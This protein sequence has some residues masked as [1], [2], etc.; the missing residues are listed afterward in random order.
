M[1][2]RKILGAL[3][4][5]A[6]CFTLAEVPAHADTYVPGTVNQTFNGS[7][8]GWSGVTTSSGLCIPAL[9]CPAASA[10]WQPGGSDGNGYIS[11]KFGSL[12]S[13]QTGTA[14]S[15][16]E[17]PVFTYA[18]LGGKEPGS[19][20]FDMDILRNVAALLDLSLLNNT[21]YQVDL[22]D[23]TNGKAVSVVPSTPIAPNGGWTSIPSA[24]VNPSLLKIGRPYKIRI[25]TDYHAAVT[26]VA[27]GEVGYDNVT[28][29]TAASNGG[30]GGGNNG[31]SGIT[32]IKQLRKLTK[33][34][35]LPS[36]AKVDGRLLVVKL[37]CPAI[38]SPKPCQ[39]QFAGLQAGR[40]SKSA[41]A[42]KIVTIKAGKERTVKIR[43]KPKYVAKYKSAKKIWTKS[44][45]RVGKVRVTVRKT[46]KV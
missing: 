18:G 17:S 19:V 15:I 32:N 46:M 31:G 44:I 39:I 36:S 6:L 4:A 29:T 22:V 3:A 38:A 9:L 40:F 27:T 20:T 2:L 34:Y 45:V 1:H 14:G 37:R 13:T 23:Q 33:T 28:L 26:V 12:A 42:R 11:T 16:W 25:K 10:T 43:I 7:A 8:G 21:S 41:T 24:D 30:G 35:I 5:S